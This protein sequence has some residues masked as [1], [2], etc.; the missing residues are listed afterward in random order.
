MVNGLQVVVHMQFFNIKSPGNVCLF[1]GF[2]AEISNFDVIDTSDFTN[3]IG[4]IPEMDAISLNFQNEGYLNNLVVPSL[5]TLFYILLA[6]ISLVAVHLLLH[7]ISRCIK[8]ADK[9]TNKVARYLY[10]NGTIRLLMESYMDLVM[11]AL[12]NIKDLDWSGDFFFVTLNNWIS[13]SLLGILIVFP[14][15][16][17]IVYVRNVK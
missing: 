8:L 10:F 9:V 16:I 13:I 11:F 6:Q 12:I 17:V 4:Y 5:G 15:L 3:K 2:F 7:I 14:F 1:I